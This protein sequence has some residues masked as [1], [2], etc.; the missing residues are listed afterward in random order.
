[1][2]PNTPGTNV[3]RTPH[4]AINRIEGVEYSLQDNPVERATDCR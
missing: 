3:R 2:T 4:A 1:M